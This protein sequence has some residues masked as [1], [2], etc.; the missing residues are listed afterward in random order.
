MRAQQGGHRRSAAALS[1]ISASS[2]CAGLG[3]GRILPPARAGGGKHC[4][5]RC[6]GSSSDVAPRDGPGPPAAAAVSESGHLAR[7]LS[8]AR[9]LARVSILVAVGVALHVVESWI[10]VPYVVPGLKL[11]LANIVTVY[12]LYTLGRGPATLVAALRSVLGSVLGGTF[13]LPAFTMS[14]AGASMSALVMGT[15]AKSS[16]TRQGVSQ[17]PALRGR[18]SYGGDLF[19]RGAWYDAEGIMNGRSGRLFPSKRLGMAGDN[20]ASR[21]TPRHGWLLK[22]RPRYGG[23]ASEIIAVSVIGAIT[24]NLS[25]LAVA[26][27]LLQHA[28]LILYLPLLVSLAIPMGTVVGLLSGKAVAAYKSCS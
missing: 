13:L 2:V 18:R 19:R 28:G 16:V 26:M 10:P 6:P 24:H 4:D 15:V 7:S 27:I 17:S 20:Q 1:C 9:D 11:G 3:P 5:N 12:A 21:E 22:R 23:L 8:A 25:Q 14:F